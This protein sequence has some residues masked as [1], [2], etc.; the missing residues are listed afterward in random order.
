MKGEAIDQISE[1]IERIWWR[2]E[3]DVVK[4]NLCGRLKCMMYGR[5]VSVV[6]S[7]T[8]TYNLFFVT[9]PTQ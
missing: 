9:D 1:P 3:W 2:L 7:N 5:A 8:K 4:C 6:S